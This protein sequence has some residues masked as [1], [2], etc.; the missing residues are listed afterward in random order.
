MVLMPSHWTVTSISPA[1]GSLVDP[2]T[3]IDI[4]C[5]K[6]TNIPGHRPTVRDTSNRMVWQPVSEIRTE[7]SCESPRGT[8]PDPFGELLG[9]RMV[10][11]GVSRW[12]HQIIVF[13]VLG[14]A[15]KLLL[16]PRNTLGRIISRTCSAC[17][18]RNLPTAEYVPLG[19][20]LSSRIAIG[21]ISVRYSRPTLVPSVV[22]EIY[23]DSAPDSPVVLAG[24]LRRP[25]RIA[26]NYSIDLRSVYNETCN[27]Q[28]SRARL[29]LIER[30]D[31]ML[32][33]ER[34][35]LEVR[36]SFHFIGESGD[37]FSVSRIGS[38]GSDECGVV[39]RFFCRTNQFCLTRKQIDTRIGRPHIS[40]GHTRVVSTSSRTGR[41]YRLTGASSQHYPGGHNRHT[42]AFNVLDC[43][44]FD[45]HSSCRDP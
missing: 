42:S 39:P 8:R 27:M 36:S 26:A 28:V 33:H 37:R 2:T 19:W 16:I 7:H 38:A 45:H 11:G 40:V 13:R 24:Q 10:W 15:G 14:E 12:S 20:H 17:D 22:L 34:S 3:E 31:R 1:A 21:R 25:Y 6:Y 4:R 5:R 35:R 43:A 30:Y 41:L 23:T 9:Y 32:G 29:E 18:R 44:A